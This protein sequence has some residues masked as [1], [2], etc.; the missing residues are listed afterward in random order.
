MYEFCW[1]GVRQYVFN[2]LTFISLYTHYSYV[3]LRIKQTN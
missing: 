1:A 2:R 3:E